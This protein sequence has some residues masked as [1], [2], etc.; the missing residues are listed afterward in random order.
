[1]NYRL[2]TY[3]RAEKA[4]F[5]RPNPYDPDQGSIKTEEGILAPV[6]SCGPVLSPSLIDFLEKTAEEAKEVGEEEEGQ[7]TDYE[8]LLSD[9]E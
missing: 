8:E 5:W 3:K 9:D 7:E 4:I 1:M 6:W 2:A